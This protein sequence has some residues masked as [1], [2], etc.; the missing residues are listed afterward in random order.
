[1]RRYIKLSI[2][3]N[4]LQSQE[5]EGFGQTKL[6]TIFKGN[7]GANKGRGGELKWNGGGVNSQFP[8][9]SR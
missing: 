9:L 4:V 3:G 7:D 8:R 1:M 6:F 2:F 5:P